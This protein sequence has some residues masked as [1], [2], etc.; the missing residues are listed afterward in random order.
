[1]KHL[2]NQ[3]FV[4]L[5]VIFLILIFIAMYFFITD[6]YNL[7]PLIFESDGVF[8][9]QNANSDSADINGTSAGGGFS[10]AEPQ[11]KALVSLGIDPARV[12]ASIT[13]GQEQCFVGALGEARVE[14]IRNG[15]V[16]NAIEFAKAKGCI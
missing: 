13:A 10:L 3:I 5:G 9:T 2:I 15:A 16:P 12:P 7:K 6:P 4:T 1:M 14:E 11:K 8:N